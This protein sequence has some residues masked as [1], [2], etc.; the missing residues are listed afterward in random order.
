MKKI[1][2]VIRLHWDR[3][4]SVREIAA[5]CGIGRTTVGEYLH[6]AGAAG[7]S[8]P[9]PDELSDAELTRLLFPRPKSGEPLRPMPDWSLVQ[10]ELS[11]QKGMTLLL[12]W[13]E[14]K[15][16]FP[17]G[18]GYSRY[19]GLY[20]SWARLGELSML[21]RHKAGEK[22]FVDWAGLKVKVSD[23]KTGEVREHPVF[24]AALGASHYL[25]CKAYESEEL[26]NWICGHV[27]AFGFYGALPEVVVP[28]NPK[29]GIEK[30]CRYEPLLNPTYA[31]L[32]QFYGIAVIPARVRKPKDKAKVENGVQQVERWVLAPLR[33]RVFFSI[34]EANEALAKELGA[35]NSKVM[36]GPN[37]SRRELFE[38]EDR[39]VMRLLPVAPYVYAEWKRLKVA[40]DYHVECE[41]HL[42]SVPFA[43]V[44]KHVDVRV[45]MNTVEVFFGGKR[46]ASHLR[47]LS[48][49]G[50][51]TDSSHMP[52]KHRKMAEWTPERMVR[53]AGV[54]G[55]GTAAFVGELLCGKVHAE[56]GFRV[57][58]GVIGLEKR[59]GTQRLDAAC[60]RAT[61]LGAFSYRSVKSILDKNLE[62]VPVQE[63]LVPLPSHQNVRGGGYYNEETSCVN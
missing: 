63:R 13:R 28:D 26:R 40:P 16:E 30:A 46:I 36:Q 53:W 21:Q 31:E 11:R 45:S 32:A 14:Y 43:F 37:L 10:K 34:E 52:E 22:L 9:L 24:V 41:R 59:F 27:E 33:D 15:G 12:L 20:R 42:Y 35:L 60:A 38:Q 1:R 44:G 62:N 3:R 51:T 25:F 48:R 5:A 7:L 19:A 2:E 39:P 54:V 29:T 58:M 57:C 47:S 61:E 4:A 17:N 6:R 18:Y 56:H 50:F 55:P 8:W 49:R 23:P